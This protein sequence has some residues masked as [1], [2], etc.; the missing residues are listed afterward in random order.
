ML[1][2][3]CEDLLKHLENPVSSCQFLVIPTNRAYNMKSIYVFLDD[4]LAVIRPLDQEVEL[5]EFYYFRLLHFS[6]QGQPFR[7]C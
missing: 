4:L 2:R 7:K 5:S 3:V 6:T 1:V